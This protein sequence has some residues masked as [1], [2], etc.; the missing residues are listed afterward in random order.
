MNV[1]N[2]RG[3]VMQMTVCHNELT[4]EWKTESGLKLAECGGILKIKES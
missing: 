3:V 4:D 1:I 2:R